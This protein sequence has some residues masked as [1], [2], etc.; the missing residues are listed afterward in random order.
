M[1]EREV[2]TSCCKKVMISFD[3]AQL[4]SYNHQHNYLGENLSFNVTK[5]FSINGSIFRL[6]NSVG[7]APVWS[8]LEGL[9]SSAIDYD[10]VVINGINFGPGKI[11]NINFTEGSD[12][13][14][15]P[16]S[17]DLTVFASGD[18]SSLDG[19]NFSGISLPNIEFTERF[20]ETFD[21]DIKE[22]GTY[23]YKQN[24]NVTYVKGLINND[25][26]LMAK[27]L[28]SGLFNSSP[29]YGFIDAEHSGF[30]NQPGRRT[31]TE[32]YN[33]ITNECSFSE[34]F[35]EPKFSGGYAI[36][37]TQEIST[38]EDGI[39]NLTERGHIEG[40][41]GADLM[42][43]ANSGLSG[44]L[45]NT[46]DRANT[47]LNAYL[48][49]TLPLNSGFLV[50]QKKINQF[51]N[52][53]DYTVQ[54]NNDPRNQIF[55]TWEYTQE[56]SR[57]NDCY[58]AIKENGRIRGL[59]HDCTRIQQYNNAVAGW[60]IVQTGI[61]DRITN[62]Y[63][64]MSHLT[65]PLNYV[66]SNIR[67]S[68]HGGEIGYDYGYTDDPTYNVTGQIKRIETQVQENLPSPLINRFL[69]PH[70]GEIAQ[71]IGIIKEGRRNAT[72]RLIGKRRTLIDAY[73]AVAQD[74]VNT[75]LPSGEDVFIDNC[76][77][78]FSPT[79][80]TFDLTIGWV[81][82]GPYAGIFV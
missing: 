38:A 32:N 76:S 41:I 72:V 69:V 30:Y 58:Y 21:F 47:V 61:L 19:P 3:D 7:V 39:S 68:V 4:L 70:V 36:R 26:M 11:N 55:Y 23:S 78:S 10:A 42:S 74:K 22:D 63:Q 14:I 75:L 9:V 77:Y 6:D 67:Q 35:T 44:E 50:L 79:E 34:N 73:L 5:H 37:Y 65:N 8:G 71:N 2:T 81:Y 57:Q 25:P 17:A 24:I 29:D 64:Q 27:Q 53:I 28:A 16:Y 56:S 12:V 46:F 62:Y 13:R 33:K 1:R 49:G 51:T 59:T 45:A 20:N 52:S 66:S 31:Y 54:Y 40:L 18:L 43:A 60:A 82:F 80:N 15:K 48:P